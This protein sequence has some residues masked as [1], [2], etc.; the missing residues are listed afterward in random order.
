[1]RE[2][3]ADCYESAF[4]WPHE[5]LGRPIIHDAVRG[6]ILRDFVLPLLEK[7]TGGF[8]HRFSHRRRVSEKTLVINMRSGKDIFTANPPP[9]SDYMQPPLSFYERVIE[10]GRFHDCLIV[11]ERDRLNPVIEPLLRRH[12]GVRLN[13]HRSVLD[14]I[15]LVLSAR[16][17]VLAHSSF[18][19][20]LALMSRNLRVLHQPSSFVVRGIPWLEV[21]TWTINNYVT[22]GEWKASEEQMGLMVEHKGEDVVGKRESL[23]YLPMSSFGVTNDAV[24][25]EAI[26]KSKREMEARMR[27]VSGLH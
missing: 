17:L 5:C 26:A 24:Q 6:I 20:C 18:T 11:T 13:E 22:P 4:F 15:A 3:S 8:F 12:S 1:M 25:L 23:E 21:T 7:R 19:W 9:Q 27:V 14:D 16:N 10:E 2:S